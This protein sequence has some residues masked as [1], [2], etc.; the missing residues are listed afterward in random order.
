MPGRLTQANSICR[1]LI[2]AVIFA[3]ASRAMSL[4][5]IIRIPDDYQTISEALS[6]APNHAVIEIAAG[7]YHEAL[8]VER[9]VTLRGDEAG[10]VVVVSPD[11]VPVISVLD[12]AAVTIEGLT[13]IGGEYGIFVTHSQNV[14][15]RNNFVSDSRLTG[16]KVR[17][18]AADILDNTV[19]NARP[20]Y[21][22]GIH[23]TNT[24]QWPESRVIGNIVVGNARSGIYTNMTAMIT[25][26]DNIVRDNG[27]HGI[28]VTE[29][30]HADVIGNLVDDNAITG[31]QLLDMSM[32]LI[33]DNIVADTRSE[34]DSMNIRQG[35]GITIDYHSEAILA[36]NT[37]LGS[38]QNGISILF[39]STAFL[40][41]NSIKDSEAQPVFVDE[42]EAPEGSGC[43]EGE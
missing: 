6:S 26:E 2:V 35:N 17:L 34:A 14:T 10:G 28:A 15:L 37:V 42:S 7:T 21:G 8:L 20:P 29:M 31:I 27:A 24:T 39:G 5:E 30:S 4:T 1:L 25:I 9:P 16:I 19:V 12:T 22:M 13:I 43:S 18:G 41:D 3:L 32:A 38:A 11:D 40:H 33:C 23:V 36:G